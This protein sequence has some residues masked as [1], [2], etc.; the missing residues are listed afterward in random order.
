M[1]LTIYRVLSF[2]LLPMAIL[3]AVAVLLLI[4]A[5]FA[6]PLLLVY[7]FI[8]ASI[9]IYTFASLNFLIRGIDG[10]NLLGKSSREWIIVNAFVSVIYSLLAVA[11]G[12][13]VLFYPEIVKTMAENAKNNAGS[14]L[15][16]SPEQLSLYINGLSYFTL[17]YGVVLFIH[18]IFSF[19]YLKKYAY[20]FQNEKK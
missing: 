2:L 11:Q 20:L 5:A 13:V 16:L 4:R 10:K 18:I 19:Q 15:V 8:G 6:N 9:S 14:A 3:F 1:K 12:L 7:L 17:T